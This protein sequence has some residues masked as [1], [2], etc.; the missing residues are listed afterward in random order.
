MRAVPIR[1]IA[2]SVALASPRPTLTVGTVHELVRELMMVLGLIAQMRRRPDVLRLVYRSLLCVL[3]HLLLLHL[4]RSD[5]VQWAG[6]G[7]QLA[8][9]IDELGADAVALPGET[10]ESSYVGSVAR[11]P[12]SVVA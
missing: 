10:T 7:A 9:E 2:Y 1:L 5:A 4:H 8:R 11:T 3:R 6:I 12:H